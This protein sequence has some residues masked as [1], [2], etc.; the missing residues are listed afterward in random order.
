MGLPVVWR[1]MVQ[2]QKEAPVGHPR[3]TT[4]TDPQKHRRDRRA[5]APAAPAGAAEAAARVDVCLAA[6]RTAARPA[7]AWTR[8]ATPDSR[9]FV[10]ALASSAAA[11]RRCAILG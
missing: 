8:R 3:S 4:V 5:V 9:L 11:S 1:Q 6:D 2:W 7:A 10:A